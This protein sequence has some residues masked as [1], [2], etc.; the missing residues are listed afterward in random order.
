MVTLLT[1]GAANHQTQAKLITEKVLLLFEQPG[2]PIIGCSQ[3]FPMILYV[4]SCHSK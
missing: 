1:S 2:S 3:I 4:Q